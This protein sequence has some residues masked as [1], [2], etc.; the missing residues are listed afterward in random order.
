MQLNSCKNDSTHA[1]LGWLILIKT[2]SCIVHTINRVSLKCPNLEKCA[3]WN[4]MKEI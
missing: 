3:T 2:F 4:L 1:Q